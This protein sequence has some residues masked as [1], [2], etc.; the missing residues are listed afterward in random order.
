MLAKLLGIL[1]I[2]SPLVSSVISRPTATAKPLPEEDRAFLRRQAA[3]MWQ[4]FETFL[5]K[6]NNYLPPDNW[7]E[8]PA[9]GVAQRTSPTNIGL[10]LLCC[11]AAHD[12]QLAGLNHILDRIENILSTI[13]KLR[14]WRG[15]I[16]N[17]YDTAT[18]EPLYPLS[19]SSVDSGNLAAAISL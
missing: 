13:E 10:A 9:L 17:W 4:Y 3:L 14:K 8:Q 7:Q 19:V 16:L 12:L 15:H 6:S 1:W 11:L 18:L 5:D 2:L